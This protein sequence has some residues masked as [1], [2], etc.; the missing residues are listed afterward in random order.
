V[1]F[2]TVNNNFSVSNAVLDAVLDELGVARLYLKDPTRF[3]YFRGVIGLSGSLRGLPEAITQTLRQNGIHRIVATGVS[4]GGLPAI[5][6]AAALDASACLAFSAY[7]DFSLNSVLPQPLVHMNIARE[8]DP[9]ARINTLDV[10]SS[11][12]AE[13]GSFRFYYGLDHP[14]DRPHALHLS[15]L[16]QMRLVGFNRCG[17]GAV[18]ALVERGGFAAAFAEALQADDASIN[19]QGARHD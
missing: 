7:T 5:Y 13:P 1:V 6:T 11:S 2:T 12:K 16:P 4:S 19:R 3:I 8:V 9:G 10:I 15:G 18:G 14:I 17:H